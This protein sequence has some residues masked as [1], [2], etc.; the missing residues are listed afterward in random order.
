MYAWP[1]DP[2]VDW[3]RYSCRKCGQILTLIHTDGWRYPVV[4][5]DPYYL[6]H[7]PGGG[8]RSLF[9]MNF[10]GHL[11]RH[12]NPWRPKRGRP[13]YQDQRAPLRAV[14]FRGPERTGTQ[15]A[16][17]PNPGDIPPGSVILDQRRFRSHDDAGSFF[18]WKTF[19]KPH[20]ERLLA[21][22]R[23]RRQRRNR[24]KG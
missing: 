24:V 9:E 16:I 14:V 11:E 23:K 8:K 21:R 3:G 20:R 15:M 10:Q 13:S 6:T 22:E 18:I 17:N 7:R 5:P 12:R 2:R 4:K 1:L 19:L